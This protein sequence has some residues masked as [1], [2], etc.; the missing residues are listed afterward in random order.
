[1]NQ[2]EAVHTV[3]AHSICALQQASTAETSV[4]R[5]SVERA[6]AELNIHMGTVDGARTSV[7]S[8]T[9]PHHT[10]RLGLIYGVHHHHFCPSVQQHRWG[11]FTMRGGF[12]KSLLQ[13]KAQ[14]A[15]DAAPHPQ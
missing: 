2:P 10:C 7:S 12:T 8:H 11:G 13:G 3:W 6:V 15:T 5:F 14:E 9:R 1:M 4:A